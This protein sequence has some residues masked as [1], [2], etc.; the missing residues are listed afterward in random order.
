M[1]IN[2]I[3]CCFL[4]SCGNRKEKPKINDQQQIVVPDKSSI[5]YLVDVKNT[6]VGWK[7]CKDAGCHHGTIEVKEGTMSVEQDKLVAGTFVI[8]MQTIADQDLTDPNQNKKLV[9]DISS[10]NFFDVPN[11]PVSKFEITSSEILKAA[12]AEGNN[13]NINGNLTIKDV[14]RNISFPATININKEK[15]TAKGAFTI[16]RTEFKLKYAKG[17]LFKGIGDDIIHK[18][19]D[20]TIDLT[21]IARNK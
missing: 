1:I 4:I 9:A 20:F 3:L 17:K 18:N 11:F 15:I 10:E 14:T 7:C 5:P 16:D 12:D 21:A 6:V 8:D 2:L 13:Y 19:I